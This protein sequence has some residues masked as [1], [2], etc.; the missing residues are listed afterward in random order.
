MVENVAKVL[1][2]HGSFYIKEVDGSLTELTKGSLIPQ[3]AVVVGADGNRATDSIIFSLGDGSDLVLLGNNTQSFDSS[4]VNIPFSQDETI[5]SIQSIEEL[6]SETQNDL[7]DE[8]TEDI[9]E[10]NIQTAAGEEVSPVADSENRFT[11]IDNEQEAID[12]TLRETTTPPN[13]D[14]TKLNNHD[15]IFIDPN[16]ELARLNL[17]NELQGLQEVQSHA[18]LA[19]QQAREATIEADLAS[20]TAQENPT[21]QNIQLS[22]IANVNALE[23][24]NNATQ[25][26]QEL[27]NMLDSVTEAG[28]NASENVDLT[29]AINTLNSTIESAQSAQT[30]A[31]TAEESSDAN[32]AELL[33]LANAAADSANEAIVT[34]Q[35]A[36]DTLAANENPTAQDIEVARDSLASAN[37][38]SCRCK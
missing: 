22:E 16:Q 2:V 31:L 7:F 14:N 21:P 17:A 5:T 4:L 23:A 15:E 10:E 1:S 3:D 6:F 27:Q 20:Q 36:A 32:I 35:D 9:D 8:I 30:S 13:D 19:S 33:S 24:A 34:A 18:I 25:A 28:I 37:T 12:V 38:A 11:Q 29:D 26:S